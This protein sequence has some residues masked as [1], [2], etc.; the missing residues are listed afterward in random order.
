M[1]LCFFFRMKNKEVGAPYGDTSRQ[2]QQQQHR[3]QKK[4]VIFII[5]PGRTGT[6]LLGE[7]F[8]SQDDIFYLFEPLRTIDVFYNTSFFSTKRQKVKNMHLHAHL[9]MELLKDIVTCNYRTRHN[10]FLKLLKIKQSNVLRQLPPEPPCQS[11][12][13][14]KCFPTITADLMNNICRKREYRIVVKDLSSRL[15]YA[16]IS[17]LEELP[18][19]ANHELL[20]IHSMRDPRAFLFSKY[21][22]KWFG[23]EEDAEPMK[24]FRTFVNATCT[25]LEQNLHH[26]SNS[27]GSRKDNHVIKYKMIRYEELRAANLT[28]LAHSLESFLGPQMI[29]VKEFFL[30][31]T[32]FKGGA[33]FIGNPYSVLPRDIEKVSDV[34]RK[35]MKYEHVKYIQDTCRSVMAQLNYKDID[36]DSYQSHM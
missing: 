18:L 7:F 21:T 11:T 10:H 28:P 22:L 16:R 32:R 12:F 14:S 33:I 3:K 15:P 24:R 27:D 25:I 13:F 23:E 6:S 20:V 8:N 30:K 36:D 31:R 5:G 17:S 1:L 26:F 35:H 19:P 34:W 29:S 4:M 9:A 2:Q